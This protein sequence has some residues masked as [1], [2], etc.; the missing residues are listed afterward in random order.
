M[1]EESYY[2]KHFL[3]LIGMTLLGG[4]GSVY[5]P[6]WGIVLYYTLAVLRPQYLWNWALPMQMR[7][8]LFAACIVIVSL[9][10]NAGRGFF[11]FKFNMIPALILG[12]GF[13]LLASVLNAH[14]PDTATEW[15]MEYAKIMLIALITSVV[16]DRLW[17]IKVLTVMMVICLGY[18]A[19]EINY[20]Y[21]FDGRLDIFHRGY[22]G[23]DN[24]GAGLMLAM[25]MPLAYAFGSCASKRW[26]KMV[27]WFIAILMLHGMLM[28]YSRGA[29]ISAL[30]GL[31][32]ILI[33]HRPRKQAL[34]IAAVAV[35]ATSMLAGEE[36]R[37]RFRSSAEFDADTSAQSRFDSWAAGWAIATEYPLTGQ[38]IRNSKYYTKN[39]GADRQGRTIHSQY[40]QIAADSGIIA[41]LVYI[42]MLI[43]AVYYLRNSRSLCREYLQEFKRQYPDK[44]PDL[45]T[46]QFVYITLGLEASL[47]IF[48]FG[49]I[50]LSMEVVELPWILM[51]MAGVTSIAT[52]HHLHMMEDSQ[53]KPSLDDEEFPQLLPTHPEPSMSFAE[54]WRKGM[55]R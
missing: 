51:V 14:Y 45:L 26:L 5:H 3:F 12:Y 42:A 49:G 32:W 28:S 25:G 10:I 24:N 20:L 46:S 6:F 2:M 17:Q 22:G 41:S 35:L 39:Y 38:G 37:D 15:G 40:I 30:F 48:A 8:S 11:R 9:I 33:H 27:S 34:A 16:V 19:W 13:M 52:R 43:A 47:L 21:I 23:L 53:Q 18:V 36:I 44:E 55:V 1:F 50:F 29:M 54:I 4:L 31:M 7:W